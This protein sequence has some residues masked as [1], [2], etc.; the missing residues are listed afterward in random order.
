M[1]KHKGLELIAFATQGALNTWLRKHHGRHEG[2]WIKLA[3]KN[4]GIRSISYEEGRESAIAFGWIDG[5][6][7]ALDERYYA[8]RFTPRRP[9]SIWSKINRDIAD[10]LIR[11]GKM[12][13]AGLKEVD[14]AKND[15]RWER[16]YSATADMKVPRD[17]QQELRKSPKAKQA[18]DKLSKTIRFGV[19]YNIQDAKRPET[20]ARRIQKFLKMLE[21]GE[22]GG[23]S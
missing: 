19:L 13:P 21:S 23:R 20:R 22:L 2:V 5:L 7:N 1:A 15:G 14:A 8:I 4:S 17:F 12:K 9:R 3:K 16:A 6:K 10:G 11:D 18:F